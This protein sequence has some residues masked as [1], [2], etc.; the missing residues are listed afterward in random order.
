[1]SDPRA[2]RRDFY[3]ILAFGGVG[4]ALTYVLDVPY[5]EG[6]KYWV[7]I[8]VLTLAIGGVAWFA[9]SLFRRWRP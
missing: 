2:E 3:V 6:W 9:L 5:R 1:M 7:G 8:P 4:I